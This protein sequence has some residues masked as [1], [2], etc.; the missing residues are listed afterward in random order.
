MLLQVRHSNFPTHHVLPQ[1]IVNI[2][3][4]ALSIEDDREGLDN[5]KVS[6]FGDLAESDEVLDGSIEDSSIEV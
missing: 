5:G 2:D 1:P 3:R 4:V 6:S